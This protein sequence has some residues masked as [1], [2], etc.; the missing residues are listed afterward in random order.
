MYFDLFVPFPFSPE[1][2]GKK[3]GKAGKAKGKAV[4]PAP[5]TGCWDAV[6]EEV[7]ADVGKQVALLGHCS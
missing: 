1:V 2:V 4:A 7:R 6:D 5:R 3:G